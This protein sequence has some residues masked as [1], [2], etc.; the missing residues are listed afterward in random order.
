MSE[1][2]GRFRWVVRLSHAALIAS[3]V[4]LSL[5][6]IGIVAWAIAF[7]GPDVSSSVYAARRIAAYVL[8]AGSLG[9]AGLWLLALYGLVRAIVANEEAV[10]SAA[11]RL[12]SIETVLEDQA[13]S[14]AHLADLATL[15]DQAK[16]LIYRDREIEAFRETIQADVMKQDYDAA[17]SLI[18]AFEKRYGLAEEAVRLRQ[19][20]QA[21]RKATVEEKIDRAI[22]RIMEIVERQEWAHAIRAS[23]R[24][25]EL[26]PTHPKVMVLPERIEESRSQI[27]R[28]LLQQ[29]GEA[30][31]KNDVEAGIRLLRELD[32]YLTPQEAAALAESARGVFRAKLHNLGVQ[33]AIHVTDQRWDAAL[34]TGE[35]IMRE[36]P[37][38]RMAQEVHEKIDLLRQ[39]A[40]P[41][42]QGQNAP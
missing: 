11:V 35:E 7:S 39:R 2:A 8:A 13:A 24:L 32:R 40:A 33:F 36:F 42:A 29:Y 10:H 16:S 4:I 3:L 26:F 9:V 23:Q 17:S 20:V 6:T 28:G 5:G 14:A 19:E 37:N 30:V 21:F 1:Q 22:A 34:A 41:A 18:D 31:S 38:T 27:K 25:G 15:S 12:R